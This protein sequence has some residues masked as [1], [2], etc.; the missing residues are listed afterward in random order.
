MSSI[1]EAIAAAKAEAGAIATMTNAGGGAVVQAQVGR[2]A[3]MSMDDLMASGMAVDGYIKV[4][5]GLGISIGDD[6]SY[7]PE[8]I[9]GIDMNG[10]AACE[11]IKSGNP[12][13]YDK[14]YDGV[15]NSKGG[16]WADTIVKHQ[17]VDTR[18]RPYR[19]ADIPFTVL[20][21][22]LGT[23]KTSKGQTL[24][25]VGQTLGVSLSTTNWKNWASFYSALR[26]QSPDVSS[27]KAII[28][29]GFEDKTNNAKN[30]WAILTFEL[31]EL[32]DAFPFELN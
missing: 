9:V 30:E 29:L 12:A 23:S 19:S 24:A 21:D 17:K 16:S 6:K 32:V 18:A 10:V 27:Q 28:K 13:T 2:A 5:Y 25:T 11:A 8:L 20:E 4:K 3:P 1:Q 15:T 7:F 31:V 26:A 14:T 22:I